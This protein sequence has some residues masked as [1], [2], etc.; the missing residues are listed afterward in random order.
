MRRCDLDRGTECRPGRK[1]CL[2]EC[3]THPDVR[4][5]RRFNR[6]AVGM[7]HS[8]RRRPGHR[9]LHRRRP[10][11][12]HRVDAAD[13]SGAQHPA[14]GFLAGGPPKLSA[15]FDL[16]LAATHLGAH[17]L[18]LALEF[19][20]TSVSYGDAVPEPQPARPASGCAYDA[21]PSQPQPVFE[22]VLA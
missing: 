22:S 17:Q 8:H 9:D 18:D 3:R 12:P 6:R 10:G 20:S 21:A 11:L 5:S 13:E 4:G 2:Q 16:S 15:A 14:I 7:T 1:P 19:A